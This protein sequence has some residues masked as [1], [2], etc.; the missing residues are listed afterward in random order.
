MTG[1]VWEWCQDGYG[2]DYDA[3]SPRDNPTGPDIGT[4]RVARGGS[5]YV[6]PRNVR[7]AYRFRGW[8]SERLEGNGFRAALPL[9]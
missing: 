9:R 8:P 3:S 7:I 6:V 5:G 2:K 4:Q 1:N